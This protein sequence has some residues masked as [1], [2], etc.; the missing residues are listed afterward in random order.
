MD[1][2]IPSEGHFDL[3]DNEIALVNRKIFSTPEIGDYLRLFVTGWESDG[4]G[5]EPLIYDAIGTTAAMAADIALTGGTGIGGMFG[6]VVGDIIG[7]FAGSEDD[8]LGNY[9]QIWFSSDSYGIGSYEDVGTEDL[10]LWFT[11]SE[12]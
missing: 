2:R 5:F 8:P 3:A 9:E 10:R 7:P 12:Y 6:G 4:E 11:I 1:L